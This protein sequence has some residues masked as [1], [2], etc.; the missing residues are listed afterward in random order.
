MILL[1]AIFWLY[2]LVANPTGMD[3]EEQIWFALFGIGI[4]VIYIGLDKI[5]EEV[6][7]GFENGNH[8]R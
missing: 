8:R 7:K 6:K 2:I 1:F 3:K 5:R 4:D